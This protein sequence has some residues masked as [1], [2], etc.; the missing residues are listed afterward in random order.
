M[1]PYVPRNTTHTDPIDTGEVRITLVEGA[2]AF[3]A[4]PSRF[5]RSVTIVGANHYSPEIKGANTPS[6]C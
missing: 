2:G 5:R 3:V 4:Y 6:A 1:T